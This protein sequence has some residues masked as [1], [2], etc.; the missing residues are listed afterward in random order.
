MYGTA[1]FRDQNM[2]FVEQLRRMNEAPRGLR[3]ALD[4]RDFG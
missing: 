3:G 2:T 4:K 1:F